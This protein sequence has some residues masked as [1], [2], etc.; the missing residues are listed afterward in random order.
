MFIQPVA[1]DYF[2]W[3]G[4]FQDN[5]ASWSWLYIG[6]PQALWPYMSDNGRRRKSSPCFTVFLHIKTS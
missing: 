3:P 4:V 5:M 1:S 6:S 2:L